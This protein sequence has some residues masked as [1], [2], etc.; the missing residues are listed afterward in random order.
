MSER[1]SVL[2]CGSPLPLFAPPSF[3]RTGW[4]GEFETSNQIDRISVSQDSGS[5]G[6]F[7]QIQFATAGQC[8][9]LREE[10]T[11]NELKFEEQRNSTPI[12]LV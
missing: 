9:N 10:F 1:G 5:A 4:T 2:A 6:F 11:P 8:W 3:D 12:W 7:P